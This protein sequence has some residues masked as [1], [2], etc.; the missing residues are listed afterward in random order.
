MKNALMAW[1]VFLSGILSAI[2]V[3]YLMRSY[4]GNI[5]TGGLPELV[6]F[7]IQ[8]AIAAFSLFLAF[9]ATKPIRMLWVRILCVVAQ[10]I[11]AFGMYLFIGL[12]YICNAGIDC[13]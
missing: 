1:V 7:F 11:V 12:S 13:I 3:D 9:K 10:S 8:I 5:K 6:W 4:D 2:L